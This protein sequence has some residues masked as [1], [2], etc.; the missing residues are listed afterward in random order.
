MQQLLQTEFAR[1]MEESVRNRLK[2]ALEENQDMFTEKEEKNQ[3]RVVKRGL[4]ASVAKLRA[5]FK[6]ETSY[7]AMKDQADAIED[8]KK[9][10]ICQD[11]LTLVDPKQL[12]AEVSEKINDLY[13]IPFT[14]Q[15]DETTLYKNIY[16]IYLIEL[17]YLVKSLNKAEKKG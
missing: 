7:Q 12:A 14:S 2:A 6:N 3:K 17:K 10:E 4:N 1:Q 5:I 8:R 16:R 13:Q 9:R 15:W 11:I